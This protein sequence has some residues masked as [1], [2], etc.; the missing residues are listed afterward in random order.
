MTEINAIA[1]FT[2]ELSIGLNITINM[3]ISNKI[4]QMEGRCLLL[5]MQAINK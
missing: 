4:I 1:V 3:S 5:A 2:C